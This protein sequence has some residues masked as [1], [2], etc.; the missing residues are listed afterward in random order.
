MPLK[1]GESYKVMFAL[2]INK[3]IHA[4]A[5]DVNVREGNSQ[6]ITLRVGTPISPVVGNIIAFLIFFL[7][8]GFS[9]VLSSNSAFT[10]KLFH[11]N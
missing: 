11:L 3:P 1:A 9:Y 8:L 6:F 5:G 4:A 10:K 7:S 2:W